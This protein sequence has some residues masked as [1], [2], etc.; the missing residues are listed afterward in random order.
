MITYSIIMKYRLESYK[1]SD[2]KIINAAIK[3][4]GDGTGRDNYVN[5]IYWNILQQFNYILAK[6]FFSM[7]KFFCKINYCGRK[8]FFRENL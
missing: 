7:K 8:Q 3:Y 6:K 1:P 5:P 4:H 2:L